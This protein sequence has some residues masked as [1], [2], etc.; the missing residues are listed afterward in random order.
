MKK[1][2]LLLTALVLA[3]VTVFTVGCGI[4]TDYNK[5]TE[6]FEKKGY[7]VNVDTEYSDIRTSLAAFSLSV[8]TGKVDCILDAEDEYEDELIFIFYC[9]DA[10]TAKEIL[11]EIRGNSYIKSAFAKT[12]GK[13]VSADDVSYGCDGSIF[14]IGTKEAIKIAK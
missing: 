11:E 2:R 1:I 3:L 13:S 4:E 12:A 5:A 6:K 9:E 14:Y 7:E 8:S 10:A